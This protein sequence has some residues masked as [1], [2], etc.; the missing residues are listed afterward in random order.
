MHAIIQHIIEKPHRHLDAYQV[1][2]ETARPHE[3]N[4]NAVHAASMSRNE[5]IAAWIADHVGT[6]LFCYTFLTIMLSYMILQSV[7]I[8]AFH[9]TP[10]DSFPFPLLFF[11]VSGFFQTFMLPILQISSNIQARRA[12]LRTESDYHVGL[13]T[14]ADLERLA[15]LIED[16]D[17]AIACLL[18]SILA[19]LD[20]ANL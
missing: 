9:G 10:F 8:P 20:K 11:L 3:I 13:D 5:Q 6:M 18:A 7:I 1:V 14:H 17:D 16:R 12:E 2:R 19:R 4:P 15:K